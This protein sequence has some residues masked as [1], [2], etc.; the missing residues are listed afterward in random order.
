MQSGLRSSTAQPKFS[1]SVVKGTMEI[2][3]I[4]RTPS[5]IARSTLIST[6]DAPRPASN[7]QG[8]AACKKPFKLVL[9]MPPKKDDVEM[10]KSKLKTTKQRRFLSPVHAC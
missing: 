2:E 8:S 9:V 3:S 5:A 6:T 4:T 7:Q 1:Y 10:A